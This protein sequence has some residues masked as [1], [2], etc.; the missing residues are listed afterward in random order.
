[1]GKGKH[2]TLW[3]GLSS[4]TGALTALLFGATAVVNTNADFINTHLGTSNYIVVDNSNGEDIDSTYFKS[5]YEKLSDLVDAKLEMAEL[6]AEEGTVLLKNDN[7]ALP[8]DI[9]SEK[10]TLW[11]MNSSNATYGGMIFHAERRGRPEKAHDRTGFYG[12]RL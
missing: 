11:G 10:V 6:I 9:S 2:S 12:K 5:D 1:M 7:A 4:V 8:L 3:R